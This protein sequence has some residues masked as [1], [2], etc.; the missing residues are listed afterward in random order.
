M[1]NSF[2]FRGSKFGAT[3]GD[4]YRKKTS[5]SSTFLDVIDDKYAESLS[6]I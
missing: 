2:N 1:I 5:F 4:N 6:L 3:Y